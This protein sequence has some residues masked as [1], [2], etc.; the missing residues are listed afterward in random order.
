MSFQ[1][2]FNTDFKKKLN[3]MDTKQALQITSIG[4]RRI[5]ALIDE[6]KQRIE[7]ALLLPTINDFIQANDEIQDFTK[8]FASEL[9]AHMDELSS[10]MTTD[11][12]PKPGKQQEFEEEVEVVK[13]YAK[14]LVRQ[15][16][17]AHELFDSLIEER[18]K[19]TNGKPKII[20]SLTT[21]YKYE[22]EYFSKHRKVDIER[23][24][25][26]NEIEQMKQIN[27]SHIETLKKNDAKLARE[28]ELKIRA[29]EEELDTI[30]K[31]LIQ[32][33]SGEVQQNDD[34]GNDELLTQE[35][36]LKAELGNIKQAVAKKQV[37]DTLDESAERKSIR[38][39]E[40]VLQQV[41]EK[42]DTTMRD[43]TTKS[44]DALTAMNK[45]ESDLGVLKT[46]VAKIRQKR[47]PY[48][49]DE[50]IFI[51]REMNSTKKMQDMQS[52][53]YT[54]QFYIRKFLLTAKKP[55]KKTR[56]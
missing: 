4:A 13:E 47:S 24:R 28:K 34:Q 51:M 1:H 36:S 20:T 10:I 19:Q 14:E 52:S 6:C 32:A 43:L 23:E 27:L 29:K 17:N 8:E 45:I 56:K 15:M 40:E 26:M 41:I 53:V 54:L 22:E 42:Y 31:L 48:M 16:S 3:S 21:V 25:V 11:G 49:N 5:L 44:A 46:E 35:E 30:K 37:S 7:F 50:R 12:E 39:S 55:V 18:D 38:K 2:L 33:K 9:Q